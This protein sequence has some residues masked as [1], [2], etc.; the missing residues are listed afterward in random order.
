MFHHKK[1]L[2]QSD[3]K[4][5]NLQKADCLKKETTNVDGMNLVVSL[6]AERDKIT[7]QTGKLA[8]RGKKIA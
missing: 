1:T 7:A 4:K 5:K 3:L 8:A 6:H 2:L